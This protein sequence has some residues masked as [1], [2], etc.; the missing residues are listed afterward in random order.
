MDEHLPEPMHIS[1]VLDR[2]FAG[3]ERRIAERRRAAANADGGTPLFP[4]SDTRHD[5]RTVAKAENR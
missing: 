4:T 1:V 3:L 2:Y 5:S